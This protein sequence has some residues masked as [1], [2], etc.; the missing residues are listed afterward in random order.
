MQINTDPRNSDFVVVEGAKKRDYGVDEMGVAVG[1][2]G[3]GVGAVEE[4]RERKRQDAFVAFEGKAAEKV[5]KVEEAERVE[6][7]R[8]LKERDWRHVDE[9]GA[10]LRAGFRVGR[11]ER[12]REGRVKEEV[13]ERMGLG[14]E[15]LDASEADTRRAG[16]VDFGAAAEADTGLGTTRRTFLNDGRK[17]SGARQKTDKPTDVLREELSGNTRAALDPF[18]GNAML[19][20][21]TSSR[22]L[23]P[24]VKRKRGSL[25]KWSTGPGGATQSSAIAK[26]SVPALVAYDSD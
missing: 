11:R 25:S 22:P 17:G 15:L 13:Q 7:L 14:I 24:G 2:V 1:S 10:R 5:R 4:E 6:E 12:Q 18:A 23:I 20:N 9:A 19:N 26:S 8:T 21:G 16:L 3:A